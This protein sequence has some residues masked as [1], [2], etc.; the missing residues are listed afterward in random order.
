MTKQSN[1]LSRVSLRRGSFLREVR[2][3]VRFG[4]VGMSATALHVTV[5]TV[6]IYY[7]M[8]PPLAANTVAFLTAFFISFGGNYVW[9]FQM[10]GNPLRAIQRFILISAT[11]FIVNSVALSTMLNN[12]PLSPITLVIVAAMVVPVISFIA[13]RY[14]G[15]ESDQPT[16][17]EGS[18][19]VGVDD[20]Q[21][22][23]QR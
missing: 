11:G 8:L 16:F 12:A 17:R 2:F 4:V 23:R 6:I 14:W 20:D 7:Q 10:P 5:A 13:S 15:F 9:T 3:A 19:P 1:C 22:A 21:E 18:Q